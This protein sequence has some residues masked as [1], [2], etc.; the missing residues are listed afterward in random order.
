MMILLFFKILISL[1]NWESRLND[2]DKTTD[3][4]LSDTVP[5][6]HF[7]RLVQAPRTVRDPGNRTAHMEGLALSNVCICFNAILYKSFCTWNKAREKKIIAR[8]K[9]TWQLLALQ[10][11]KVPLNYTLSADISIFNILFIY[12]Y[13]DNSVPNN[14]VS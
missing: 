2:K 7:K 14:L 8:I 11:L 9:Y 12:N 4:Q 13:I 3:A 5:M 10:P 1:I 6:Q